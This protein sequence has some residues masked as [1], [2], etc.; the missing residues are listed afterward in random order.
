MMVEK[1]FKNSNAK[2]K[3]TAFCRGRIFKEKKKKT[4]KKYGM[5]YRRVSLKSYPG[6][7]NPVIWV[8]G[9]CP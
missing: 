7:Q 5:T 9:H 4:R 3:I 6:V 8:P 2:T 1:N